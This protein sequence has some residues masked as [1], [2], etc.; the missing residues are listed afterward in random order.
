MKKVTGASFGVRFYRRGVAKDAVKGASVQKEE[1]V[2]DIPEQVA[3]E[4][5]AAKPQQIYSPAKIAKERMLRD[6]AAAGDC[7]MIRHLVMDGVDIDARDASGRTALNIAT[8]HNQAQ[9]IKTILA[10]REMQR[11]AKLGELPDTEFYRRFQKSKTG[12]E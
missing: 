10:A 6:A 12:S 3:V 11:L 7:Y 2:Q 1:A 4:T 9:A 5:Q 8:Q